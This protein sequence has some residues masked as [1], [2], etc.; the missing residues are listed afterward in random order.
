MVGSKTG[1][2]LNR[3]GGDGV[4]EDAEGERAKTGSSSGPP[5]GRSGAAIAA[6]AWRSMTRHWEGKDS[7]LG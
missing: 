5:A 3:P 7:K 2:T 1:S 6:G 4:L